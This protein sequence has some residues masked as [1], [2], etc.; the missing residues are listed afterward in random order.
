MDLHTHSHK[1]ALELS[2]GGESDRAAVAAFLTALRA[3]GALGTEAEATERWMRT[4]LEIAVSHTL[5]IK[6]Q[7]AA[8]V[9]VLCFCVGVGGHV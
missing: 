1:C 6:D 7:T 4:T 3:S 2:A 5:A 8:A 9:S